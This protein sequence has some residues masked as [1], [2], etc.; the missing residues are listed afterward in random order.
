MKMA[1]STPPLH[2][3]DALSMAWRMISTLPKAASETTM[4]MTAARVMTRLRRR[5]PA[6]SRTT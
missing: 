3:T 5:L 2:C 6:V 1:S 4:V